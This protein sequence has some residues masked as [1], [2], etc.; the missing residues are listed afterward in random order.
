MTF[1]PQFNSMNKLHNEVGHNK[2]SGPFEIEIILN[3]CKIFNRDLSV[4]VLRNEQF[5]L[6]HK[7]YYLGTGAG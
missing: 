6:F 4:S 3:Y 7:N 5:S 1:W 2:T